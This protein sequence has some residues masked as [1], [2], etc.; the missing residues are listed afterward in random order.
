L[1]YVEPIDR[2][3]AFLTVAGDDTETLGLRLY[4]G[5]TGEEFFSDTEMVFKV[6]D[7]IG[8]PK[9]PFT[10]RFNGQT[11]DQLLV[12]PNPVNNGEHFNVVLTSDEKA[13]V[14]IINSVGV[15]VLST[16]ATNREFVMDVPTA[17]GVYTIRVITDEK[18]VK[19]TRLIVK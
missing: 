5:E 10:V 3:V 14:E 7:M 2:Y 1:K 6:D 4:N 17:P 12:Y 19:C 8:N 13:R 9:N 16:K 11:D 15:V 18:N